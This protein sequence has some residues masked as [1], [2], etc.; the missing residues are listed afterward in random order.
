MGDFTKIRDEKLV[1]LKSKKK[2][3]QKSIESLPWILRKEILLLQKSG[4]I[5]E[6][7]VRFILLKKGC[8]DFIKVAVYLLYKTDREEVIKDHLKK[9]FCRYNQERTNDVLFEIEIFWPLPPPL[10]AKLAA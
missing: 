8:L 1:A 10:E 7:K 6:F 3:I 4:E 2:G 9:V 5:P